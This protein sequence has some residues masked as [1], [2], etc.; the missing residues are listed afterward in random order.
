LHHKFHTASAAACRDLGTL[1]QRQIHTEITAA[2]NLQR[3]G[4]PMSNDVKN[5]NDRR[6][7]PDFETREKSRIKRELALSLDLEPRKGEAALRGSDPYNTS[8]SFDRTKNWSRV[9][10][11]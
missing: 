1:T 3:R 8:G 4:K 9:G 7:P 5:S 6:W 2:G 11:R 10:K